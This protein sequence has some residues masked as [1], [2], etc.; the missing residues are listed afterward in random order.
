MTANLAPLFTWRSAIAESD[1]PSTTRHVALALSIYMNERGGSAH[2]GPT[3]L[4]SDT[5][6]H[7]ST[8]KE[9]LAE[10]ETKGW[11]KCISRGGI[12]GERKQANVY[13][14]S[15]PDPSFWATRRPE[16]G[17]PSSS[18]QPPVAV[19]DPNSPLNSPLNSPGGAATAVA[20]DGC[21]QKLVSGYVDDYRLECQGHDPPRN[22]RS[23]AGKAVKSALKDNE[24]PEDIARC[25]GVIAH[26]GKNP[27][28]LA[29]VLGDMHANRPRRIR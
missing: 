19:G 10:L 16:R 24:S 23:A 11:L 21:V 5:G 28:A 29:Y 17:D 8:V 20:P 18:P 14:A 26:E 3:R 4:A 6:L 7:V 15:Q 13:V 9:K 1:L 2:P 12:R 22:F 27:S 25:L